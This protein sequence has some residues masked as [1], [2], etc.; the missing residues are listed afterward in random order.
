MMLVDR[1]RHRRVSCVSRGIDDGRT[2]M[3]TISRL[4]PRL[5]VLRERA[6][7]LDHGIERVTVRSGACRPCVVVADPHLDDEEHGGERTFSHVSAGLDEKSYGGV[8]E[9][10]EDREARRA[11][12][13]AATDPRAR[14]TTP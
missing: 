4:A 6:R 2:L 5:S 9:A 14:I 3:R 1:L 11:L 7:A 10:V 8:S 12:R 13:N